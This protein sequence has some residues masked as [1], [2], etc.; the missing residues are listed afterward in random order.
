MASPTAGHLMPR[1]ATQGTKGTRPQ[2]DCPIAAPQAPQ[3]LS[4][5]CGHLSIVLARFK[6]SAPAGHPLPANAIPEQSR[7]PLSWLQCLSGTPAGSPLLCR[8]RAG[9]SALLPP[10]L[11]WATM[12][13]AVLRLPVGWLLRGV[14]LVQPESCQLGPALWAPGHPASALVPS[15]LPTAGTR[16]DLRPP[17]PGPLSSAP[18]PP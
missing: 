2:A 6:A 11:A 15:V 16:G 12:R 3:L 1:C 10:G 8:P 13:Q 18:S 4:R 7:A 17:E 5:H 14:S 9:D